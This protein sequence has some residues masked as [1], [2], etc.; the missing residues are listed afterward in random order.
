MLKEM[1]GGSRIPRLVSCDLRKEPLG[2]GLRSRAASSLAV[3]AFACLLVIVAA[4]PGFGASQVL[5]KGDRG[6]VV[7]ELQE[8]LS[9]AGY[10]SGKVDG[11]FGNETEQAVLRFQKEASLEADG[12]VGPRTWSAL[13]DACSSAVRKY[14]VVPGDT[15]Y[16]IARRH[17]CTVREIAEASGLSQ[18]DRIKPGQELLIPVQGAASRS[19]SSRGGAE[20]VSW[21]EA[22]NV[23]THRATIIDVKTGLSFQVQ[24]RGGHNHADAEP[25]TRE[26]TATM[27]RIYG[28]TWSWERRAVV[29]VAGGRRMAASI[30]GMPHGGEAIADNGFPGHFCV[31][32]LGSRTHGSNS[33][34]A[35]HQNMVRAAVGK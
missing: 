9:I 20:L 23:F 1:R 32:F 27:K 2:M 17:G 18:P 14:V 33:V 24:R 11:I 15:L 4:F 25:L 21:S 29:V 16:G 10:Y 26:D 34:D 30:N 8:Y 12:I 5:R 31:H 13:M 22:R 35:A 19:A 3:L 7:C 6:E 28:G